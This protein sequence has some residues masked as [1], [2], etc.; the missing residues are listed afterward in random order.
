MDAARVVADH[1]ADGAA[2]VTGR[3]GGKGQM[4][5]FR[6]VAQMVEHNAGLHAGDA[7]YGIDLEDLSHVLCEVED[8][9]DVAALPRERS[10]SSAAENGSTEVAADG[11]RG[12]NV[13]G[14]VPE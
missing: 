12:E 1:A 14:I 4:M 13:V 10:A 2:V 9:R 6:G 3:V 5:L 8:D 11:K 7:A